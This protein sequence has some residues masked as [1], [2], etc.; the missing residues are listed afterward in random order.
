MPK[1]FLEKLKKLTYLSL[2]TLWVSKK[3]EV[4]MPHG[5]GFVPTGYFPA[6]FLLMGLL[7]CVGWVSSV[8]ALPRIKRV[9]EIKYISKQTFYINLGSK[10]GL[11]IGDTLVVKRKNRGIGVLI[12]EHV[13][14]LSVACRSV[15][16]RS[17]LKQGDL[18]EFVVSVK[19][20]QPKVSAPDSLRKRQRKRMSSSFQK[21]VKRSTRRKRG[22]TNIIQGRI[23]LQA[24]GLDESGGAHL[25]YSQMALRAGLK[26]KRFLGMPLNFRFR[27]RSRSHHRER[28]LSSEFSDNEWTHNVYELGLVYENDDSPY[29]F[30]FGRVL[31]HRI[32]GIGYVDGGLFSAK[33]RGPWRVGLAGGTQPSLRG[34][35]FQTEEQKFGIFLNFEEGEHRTQRISSTVAFSG[36]YHQGKPSREFLYLQNNFW[37]GAKFSIYQTLEVDINRGWKSDGRHNSIQFSNLFVSTHLSPRETL[38]L[39]L[40]YDARKSVRVFET[41]SIPD[42][43]FDETTRQ[44]LHTGITLRLPNHIRLSGNFG[45]RFRK[46]N[47]K[48]TTSA[49]AALSVRNVFNTFASI[50]VRFSYF[51]TMFT[52]GYRPNFSVRI[53][54]RRELLL[55]LGAGSY[56][57]QTG[58]KTTR[59]NWV[60][61]DSYYHLNRWLFANLGYRLFFDERLRSSRVFVETGVVF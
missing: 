3:Q 18:V 47:L 52:K 16:S 33:M 60:Q 36:R 40:S 1:I 24:L 28:E 4:T 51:S 14:K 43:L 7:C 15:L 58:Y 48:N 38:S 9:G 8:T 5:R 22:E 13:S 6:I 55:N 57:Y 37:K 41:R 44:G 11:G 21:T 31:S 17:K 59:S 32:R 26:V 53:P 56:V 34:S 10:Q 61:V 42:S 19:P 39:T 27:W 25:D 35:G 29:E 54:I 45:M 20:S 12:V 30:G 46:G 50:N 49:S 2:G 23:S